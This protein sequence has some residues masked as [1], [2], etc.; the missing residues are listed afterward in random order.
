MKPLTN[1]TLVKQKVYG[2]DL[3]FARIY[4]MIK[5]GIPISFSMREY[6]LKEK[7]YYENQ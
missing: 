2:E 1:E 3:E 4:E 6:Y 7:K 5:M